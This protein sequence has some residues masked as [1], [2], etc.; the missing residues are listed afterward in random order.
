[1][2]AF[3][4]AIPATTFVAKAAFP[5]L[6]LVRYPCEVTNP[7]VAKPLVTAAVTSP[8]VEGI[9]GAP[10]RFAYARFVSPAPLPAN[11]EFVINAFVM[12]I[13]ATTFV[14]KA[15]LPP[16]ALVRYPCEITN[17][18]VAKPLVTAAVTSPLVDGIAG[19]P[20]RFAYARF[21]SPAPLPANAE[22]VMK[23]FV[24]EIPA[25]TFVAN[26]ALPPLAL[27]R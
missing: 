3:V 23:A 20:T 15:A 19:A 8:L 6:A 7:V 24:M 1:M 21:V 5:P 13:P 26:A 27:V 25:T 9:T 17:P 14:A 4:M 16:F 10:T 18:V 2:N 11:A 12:A 22:F